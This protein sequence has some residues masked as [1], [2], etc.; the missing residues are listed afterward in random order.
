MIILSASGMTGIESNRNESAADLL[1]LHKYHY[2]A[3]H[4]SV[5]K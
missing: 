2:T 5:S 3:G 1:N 4:A